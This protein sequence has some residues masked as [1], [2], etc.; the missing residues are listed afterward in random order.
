MRKSFYFF[1]AL[2]FITIMINAQPII[3]N[4][5]PND[6]NI[7]MY[8]KFELTVDLTANYT[9]P[10]DY[11]EFN[12]TAIFTSPSGT[13]DTVDGFYCQEYT[14]TNPVNG[15]IATN[16]SPIWKI[17]FSPTEVGSWQYNVFCTDNNGVSNVLTQS[18]S[19]IPST[20]KGFIRKSNGNYMKFDDNSQYFPIGTNYCWWNSNPIVDYRTWIDSLTNYGGNLIRIWMASWSFALEWNNTGL[21]NYSNNQD[22]AFYLDWLLDYSKQKDVYIELCLNN[23]GQVS[24][25]TN[26]EWQSNPYNSVNGGPCLN[27]WDFFTNTSAKTYYKNRLRYI[28][29]RWGYSPNIFS[30]E[31]FNEVEWTDDFASHANEITQWTNEMATYIKEK[32]V[33]NHLISTSYA[34]EENDPYT[35]NLP[36]IDYTQTHYYEESPELEKIINSGTTNYI[37]NFSKPTKNGEFGLNGDP[38]YMST[39]DSSGI[40]LHNVIWNTAFSG[41]FGTGMSW[42]WDNYIHPNQIYLHYKPLSDYFSTINLL[43]NN[44]TT[45]N[46]TCQSDSNTTLNI[47][48]LY[49]DWNTSPSNNFIV[50]NQGEITPNTNELGKFL[51]GNSWNTQYR[52]P[53]TFH[54][55]YQNN[56]VFKVKT[57]Q[58]TGTSPTIEI[59]LDGN[60]ILNQPANTNSTYSINIPA[61]SHS[62]LVDNKGT[63]WIEISEFNFEN[64]IPQIKSTALASPSMV[65]GWVHNRNYNWK[66]IY[67]NGNPTIVQNG[68][69]IINNLNDGVYSIDWTNCETGNLISTVSDTSV[70]GVMEITCP[71]IQW[72]FAYKIYFNQPLSVSSTKHD[73]T[74]L[75]Y[76]NP[77]GNLLFIKESNVSSTVSI[78]DI[79]GK[80]VLNQRIVNNSIDVENLESGI[81]FL[82]I[83]T[84]NSFNTYKFVKQ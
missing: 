61:G 5:I 60:L 11:S 63:D 80:M 56:G 38:N 47:I 41:A 39:H 7:G 48:P 13:K 64:Y 1:I 74:T 53:P 24:T 69:I 40:C 55:N 54:V 16:G 75:I 28:I 77:V 78:F 46:P 57:G 45:I 4:A 8:E 21:G 81:Y 3:S 12:L 52:N 79:S 10:Y 58:N 35:W 82:K 25:I 20:L 17:R 18:F 30:W 72:D 44:F 14:I 51:F 49:L 76:P 23:H 66:Y 62:I 2:M 36:I 68:K 59:W 83:E 65:F 15:T 19:C 31:K 71:D 84:N 27:T 33:N 26:P 43:S 34:K 70:G 32:D 73:N 9:N 29:A 37:N 42:W 6:N 67:D 50:S 22:R